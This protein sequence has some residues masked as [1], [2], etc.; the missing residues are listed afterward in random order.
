MI[1]HK[2]V[3]SPKLGHRIYG[4]IY[5][6]LGLRALAM[7]L[8]FMRP[9]ATLITCSLPAMK[10]TSCSRSGRRSAAPDSLRWLQGAFRERL[11]RR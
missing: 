11:R 6:A 7:T 5:D 1:D 8:P 4:G 9:A 3:I 2:T 10:P